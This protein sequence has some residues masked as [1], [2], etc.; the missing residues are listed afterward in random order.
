MN[1]FKTRITIWNILGYSTL[2]T[3]VITILKITSMVQ[4]NWWYV[5][6][7][8]WGAILLISLILIAM[9]MIMI[10]QHFKDYKNQNK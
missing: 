8:L 1:D 9:N 5:M 4:Y 3:M 7:P 6:S 10:F 2:I